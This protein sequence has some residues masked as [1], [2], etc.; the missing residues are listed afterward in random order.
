MKH[1]IFRPARSF[2]PIFDLLEIVDALQ[3]ARGL[4][5]EKGITISLVRDFD[6]FDRFC[7]AVKGRRGSLEFSSR[8]TDRTP[9]DALL[10]LGRSEAGEIVTL[11][12]L[13]RH[14]LVGISL[15]DFWRKNLE[16]LYG[17]TVVDTCP[18]AETITGEK[19]VYHGESWCS[20]DWRGQQIAST[21]ALLAHTLALI[22]FRPDYLYGLIE[23]DLVH[24]GFHSREGFCHSQPRAITWENIPS[25]FVPGDYLCWNT[26]PDL[27]HVARHIELVASE[28]PSRW[29]PPVALSARRSG[30]PAGDSE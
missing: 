2:A 10:I 14:A 9:E 6:D 18:A 25:G 23:P 3:L 22:E 29:Q 21:A 12:A 15:A 1:S 11:Q 20:P 27:L 24:R 17:E 8:L 28:T 4:L 26:L 30:P 5:R 19:V 7:E 13:W 16:R